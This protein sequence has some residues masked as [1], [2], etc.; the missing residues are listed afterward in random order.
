MKS[1]TKWLGAMVL[2]AATTAPVEAQVDCSTLDS[3]CTS[4]SCVIPRLR[5]ADPCI[6]DFGA[7]D[8]VLEGLYDI[9]TVQ[10][11][12]KSFVIE[13]TIGGRQNLGSGPDLELNATDGISVGGAIRLTTFNVL[14]RMR[15]VAGGTIEVDGPLTLTSSLPQSGVDETV[16][17]D[18]GS[19]LNVRSTIRTANVA[20]TLPV[21]LRAGGRI[22]LQ[23][24]LRPS[25]H[26]L[27]EAGTDL[28]IGGPIVLRDQFNSRLDITATAGG[29]LDVQDQIRTVGGLV[30]LEGGSDVSIARSVKSRKV[31]GSPAG[32]CLGV[33]IRSVTG[34]VTIDDFV[35]CSGRHGQGP[36]NVEAASDIT[37]GA[38]LKTV[39]STGHGGDISLTSAS[40]T[41]RVTSSVDTRG[42]VGGNLT[43]SGAEAEVTGRTVDT[44][45]RLGAGG[46]QAFAATGGDLLLSGRFLG[47]KFGDITGA[48]TGNLT[49]SGTFATGMDGCIALAAGGIL[50]TAAATFDQPLSPSCP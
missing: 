12:A 11:T 50:D 27:L 19:D 42:D 37:V 25:D 34:S 5:P 30:E 45:G 7:R 17:L 32:S 16:L 44:R 13:G 24:S 18:A 1:T 9:G 31:Q 36:L 21:T 8:V 33:S 26:L 10:L 15:I 22:D 4:G 6:V 40:G 47:T 29:T 3:L 23:A 28:V 41:I 39:S 14:P 20:G 49:A 48:A 2:V 43:I 35:E 38:R 46:A